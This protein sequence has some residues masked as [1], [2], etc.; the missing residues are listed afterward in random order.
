M[1]PDLRALLES[2]KDAPD[3]L[4]LRLILADW[5]E[6]HGEAERAEVVRLSCALTG[7][8]RLAE[9]EPDYALQ[10]AR[11]AELQRGKQGRS[12]LA[13]GPLRKYVRCWAGLGDV[14]ALSPAGFSSL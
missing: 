1:S 8:D 12:W 2:C 11:F 4:G 7:T 10:Q 13:S 6:E 5:L 3:E 9:D 14:H